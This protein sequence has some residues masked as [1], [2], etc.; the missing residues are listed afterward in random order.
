[1]TAPDP[2]DTVIEQAAKV[3]HATVCCPCDPQ[4]CDVSEVAELG[5]ARALHDAGLLA[6][7]ADRDAIK[8]PLVREIK[9]LQDQIAR[10]AME[11]GQDRQKAMHAYAARA[12]R[13]EAEVARLSM[14][15][16]NQRDAETEAA[17]AVSDLATA[18]AERDELRATVDRV[19][20]LRDHW[21]HM[22]GLAMDAD[23]REWLDA[24]SKS[25]RAALDPE[26]GA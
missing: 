21:A 11:P 7:P 12:E 20:T 18:E 23:T 13:A 8:A 2:A 16:V 9:R 24:A 17:N 25:L 5:Y 1:M 14:A 19:T 22:A 3:M 10:A 26:G 4:G 15:K 6:D